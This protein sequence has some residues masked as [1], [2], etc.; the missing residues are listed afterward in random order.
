MDKMTSNRDPTY[1]SRT[2][3]FV[4]L[5]TSL[6]ENIGFEFNPSLAARVPHALI[7][8]SFQAKHYNHIYSPM[9]TPTLTQFAFTPQDLLG[10]PQLKR[11]RYMLG[12]S[13]HQLLRPTFLSLL[14]MVD[15]AKVVGEL[16][17]SFSHSTP[18]SGDPSLREVMDS[19]SSLYLGVNDSISILHLLI[20]YFDMTSQNGYLYKK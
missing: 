18:S 5:I 14:R 20:F 10:T 12:S 2:L 13:S 11:I 16:S 7:N 15:I 19:I 8:A 3:P 4:L 6:L 1:R 17:H 9:V